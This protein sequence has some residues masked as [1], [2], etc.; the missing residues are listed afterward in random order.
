VLEAT[1]NPRIIAATGPVYGLVAEFGPQAREVAERFSPDAAVVAL[2]LENVPLGDADLL[3]TL[4]RNA[5]GCVAEP[6]DLEAGPG[7]RALALIAPRGVLAAV[8]AQAS[9][10]A[11]ADVA[12]VAAEAL[13]HHGR[14]VF[15]IVM[16]SRRLTIGPRPLIMGILNVTP[17]SFSDGGLFRDP[18]R[19]VDQARRLV[20]EGADIID[21]GGESTRPGSDPVPEDEELARVLPV[22]ETLAGRVDVP[23]SIDTRHARVAREAVA[24]GACLINDVTGLRGDPDMPRAVAE[25]GAGAVLMH[26][27]GEPK[28]MQDRPHYR[29]VVADV[30]RNLRQGMALAAAAGVPQERVLV[31]PGIGFGKTLAHNLAL[32]AR[33]DELRTLGRPVLVGPSRKRFLGEITGVA[34]PAER[35]AGTVAACVMAAQRGAAVLRV[36]DVRPVR[37]ALTVAEAIARGSADRP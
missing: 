34:D 8:L 20:D 18:A 2:I 37:E 14:R 21:V 13:E 30:C 17:D 12:R 23:L 1:H 3:E 6:R 7:T 28:S 27:L 36:H 15:E 5:G 24:A 11:A 19:A 4:I 22:V 29:H 35:I 25:T 26:M 10:G 16:G 33:L 9:E 32:L 31:D